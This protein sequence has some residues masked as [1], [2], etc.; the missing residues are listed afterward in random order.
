MKTY[1]DYLIDFDKAEPGDKVW[2][3]KYGYGEI[4]Q[5]TKINCGGILIDVFF[6]HRGEKQFYPDGRD[7]VLDDM[8]VL[9][10]EKPEFFKDRKEV[11]KWIWYYEYIAKESGSK[12][13]Q[14]TYDRHSEKE[15]LEKYKDLIKYEKI[16]CTEITETIYE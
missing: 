2:C 13:Q 3:S 5:I 12:R 8:P 15:F 1:K 6:F 4:E 9:F 10:K 11:K 16:D 7:S 14:L